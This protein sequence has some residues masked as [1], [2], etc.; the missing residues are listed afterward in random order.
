VCALQVCCAPRSAVFALSSIRAPMLSLGASTISGA[1]LMP[2]RVRFASKQG[3]VVSS[4]AIIAIYASR[5][6]GLAVQRLGVQSAQPAGLSHPFATSESLTPARVLFA[7]MRCTAV[8][9][10]RYHFNSRDADACSCALGKYAAHRG[11][12]SSLSFQFA[13]QCYL[14]AH[15]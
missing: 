3:N 4:L 11:Q 6:D 5:C 15:P 2:P 14:S 12:R 8:S 9:R 1:T 7:S 10:L 13:H